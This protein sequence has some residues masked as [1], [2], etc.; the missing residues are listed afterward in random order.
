MI[1]LALAAVLL[2][3][4]PSALRDRMQAF[5]E[6]Q[7]A[8]GI[9][10]VVGTPDHLDVAAVGHADR[11]KG[12]PM[13]A[14]AIFRIASMT[15]P[16]TA[17]AILLLE[18]E[19]RLSVDDPVEKHL[20]EF[21]GQRM[22]KSKSP[23]EILLV[24]APR[25][26]TI[27]D[28]A[29]HTSGLPGA[30][31]PGLS[32]LYRRRH[33][34]LA[35]AVAAFSQMP[36]DF[37]PGT[38]WAYCNTGIDTLGRVVEAV[39]G[40]SFEAFLSERLFKPLGMT[41]TFFYPTPELQPRIAALYGKKGDG[42]QRIESFIGDAPDGRYPL[43]AGGLYST[44]SDLARLCRMMLAGGTW[45]GRRILSEAAVAKMTSNQTGDLK[46]G[47][48]PGVGMGLGWQVV[49]EPQGVTARLSPGTY[50]H[51]GAFGTQ[52][53]IDPVKKRFWI[54]LVQRSGFPNG[55]ASPLRQALHEAGASGE[56]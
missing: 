38:K 44:A 34:T 23:E 33:R 42:L 5:V 45:E 48:T 47:F 36:L 11:E 35:E 18:D 24:R 7:E 13:K 26:I 53:W 43:P 8:A 4:E 31:P 46:A 16:L 49:R 1:R 20:P 52:Y 17:L 29:T 25:P 6:R 10:A 9:V 28:L 21:K 12:V 19:G 54:L 27:R 55:D 3:Q 41:D 30:P 14:D 22:V 40:A 50:G 39:A 15:K 56:R 51:G 37:E 2:G 32:D